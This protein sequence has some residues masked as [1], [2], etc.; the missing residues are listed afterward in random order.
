ME[1]TSSLGRVA[2]WHLAVFKEGVEGDSGW[3]LRVTMTTSVEGGVRDDRYVRDIDG[4][5][6]LLREWFD[7]VQGESH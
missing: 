1:P 6:A 7:Q 2:V 5:V 4:A 3:R